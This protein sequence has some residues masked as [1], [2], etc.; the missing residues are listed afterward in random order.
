[1]ELMEDNEKLMELIETSWKYWKT[2]CTEATTAK[3]L[4]CSLFFFFLPMPHVDRPF[5]PIKTFP[6]DSRRFSS[7]LVYHGEL[8]TCRF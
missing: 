4:I 6:P 1:M 7:K 5:A 3:K 2:P 8:V